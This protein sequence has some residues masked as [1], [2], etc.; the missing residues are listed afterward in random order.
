[1]SGDNI[2]SAL[3]KYN[4][5]TD[6]NYLT[7]SFVFLINS[8]LK[9]E[10]NVGIMILNQLCSIDNECLFDSNESIS[11]STQDVTEQG[12]P[13]IRISSPEKLIYVEVKHESD[14]GYRQIERYKEALM[15]SRATFKR[16]I[17]LTR[18]PVDFQNAEEKPDKHIRWSK[19]YD[20]LVD[21]KYQSQDTINIY[22][23]EH[24][25]SFLEVKGMV[26][27]TVG[28]EYVNGMHALN[29]LMNMIES[30]IET[31]GIRFFKGYPRSAG[32]DFKGFWIEEKQYW[33][34]IHFNNPS[35]LTFEIADKENFNQSIVG[36]TEYELKKGK[37]RL[38]FRL[39]LEE[40]NFFSLNK[41]EQLELI[42]KFV[43]TSYA[44]ANKMRIP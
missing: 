21:V 2:F 20:W 29:S 17:L 32:W 12:T 11:V 44:K 24:F 42:T 10:P 31:S 36:T 4:S 13:D 23:L 35:V 7:E 3:A 19:V 14:L 26:I 28:L 43:K 25:M 6:E 8:L 15:K 9:R 27:K 18:Y 39:P 38:W 34:G 33:C 30:A 37:E 5:A 16:I 41:D 22:L 1:M 40:H